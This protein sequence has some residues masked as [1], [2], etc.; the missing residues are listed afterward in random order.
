VTQPT[1]PKPRVTDEL[2]G[3]L[4]SLLR[5]TTRL[6]APGNVSLTAAATLSTLTR[7]GPVRLS[8]L[9]ASEQVTQPG[10]TQLV[11]RLERAGLV[12]RR[13]DPEDGRAILI[14]I[15]D[16]GRQIFEARRTNRAQQISALF[17][18]LSAEDRAAIASALP[19]LGRLAALGGQA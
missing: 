12:E 14:S 4:E 11:T 17:D 19:A 10:M 1:S 13:R 3:V 18:Q 7:T 15:T 16:A 9:T 2:T 5:F 8:E 6:H